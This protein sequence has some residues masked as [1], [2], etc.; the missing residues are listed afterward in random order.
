MTT[1][2]ERL[3]HI[4]V[5]MN[6]IGIIQ[7]LA[8][9][10]FE[11]VLPDGLTRSQFSVLNHFVRLGGPRTPAQLA[12]AFQVTKGAM[13]NTLKKL[14]ARGCV[15]SVPSPTDGRSKVIAITPR[16]RRLREASIVASQDNLQELSEVLDAD[17]VSVLLPHLQE[18]RKFLD[19]HR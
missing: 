15:K 13:T 7:Q 1:D 14:T 2:D 16:G 12:S 3:G 17:R 4:F 6:E 11:R 19:A 9:S 5:L 10:R 18:L 8:S